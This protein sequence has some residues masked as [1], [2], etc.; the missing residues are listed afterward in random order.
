MSPTIRKLLTGALVGVAVL[1][2]GCSAKND[3]IPQTI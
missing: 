1:L 2:G 3:A